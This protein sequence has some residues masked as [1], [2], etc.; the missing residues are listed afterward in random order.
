MTFRY[1]LTITPSNEASISLVHQLRKSISEFDET[2]KSLGS[3]I[4]PRNYILEADTL[5]ELY[6]LISDTKL[7]DNPTTINV[8][9]ADINET[10]E[11]IVV[12]EVTTLLDIGSH[13][14]F[15]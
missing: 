5:E 12:K 10:I 11:E 14:I 13:S 15:K 4:A 2:S 6:L 1:T 8:D 3:P 7:S 9:S